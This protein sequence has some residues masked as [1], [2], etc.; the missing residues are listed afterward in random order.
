MTDYPAYP[1]YQETGIPW[2]GEIPSHWEIRR[3]KYATDINT[4]TL[5][6]DTNPDY[7]LHYVDIGSVDSTGK[8]VE[9]QEMRFEKAP[10][11][12]RRKT[13]QG[14][15]IISTVRTYLKAIAFIDNQPENLIASTGFAVL[16]PQPDI[17]PR[18]LWRM[19]Q[20]QGFV[21]AVVANSEGIGYPAITSTQLGELPVWIPPLP[22]QRAIAAFLDER[23]A[24]LDAAAAEYH[25]LA[26]LLREQRAAL[27]SHAVTQGLDPDAPRKESGIEWLGE[28]PSHWKTYAIKRVATEIQTGSTPPT[29]ERHYYQD[30]SVPWF[31]PSSF[32]NDLIL[33]KP[34]KLI[35]RTAIEEGVAKLYKKGSTLIITI[36]ATLGKVGY[37]DFPA[38]SN[39][40]ITAVTFKESYV[41]P[42]FASYQLKS[43]EPA[44][45]GFA[46]NTTL[47]ILNQQDISMLPV[48]LPSLP[49][50]RAITAYL[51]EQTSSIDAALDEIDAAIGHLEEY[52]GA[53]IAAAVTGKIDVRE[54]V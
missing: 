25:R 6:E 14:D 24:R 15:T 18:Y 20:S 44:M 16:R 8:I 40:Q 46:P 31:G 49:E 54:A 10:S 23:T 35:N 33:E 29:S 51:D 13:Q 32:G 2:L 28:I 42:K 47:P 19:V 3:L 9:T 52:R 27:I 12:A 22:E 38:S 21:D 41:H 26:D 50:Q 48:L 7:V 4:N 39:Q 5:S 43:F 30:G 37:L 53:L 45:Q 36:G 17:E 1:E 34:V 11:R